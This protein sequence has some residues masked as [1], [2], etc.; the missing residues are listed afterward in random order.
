MRLEVGQPAPQFTVQDLAGRTI[1]LSQY[2]GHYLMISFHRYAVCPLCDLRLWH[3]GRLWEQYAR[4]GLYLMTFVEST[5]D[6][7]HWYLDR[8][9]CPFP[10]VPDPHGAVYR[11]YG[12]EASPLGVA[13]GLIGRQAEYREAGRRQLGGW[14][15]WHIATSGTFSRLPATFII[16]PDLRIQLAHYGRD[17]G[18]FLLFSEVDRFLEAR[19]HGAPSLAPPER[20]AT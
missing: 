6:M 13:R 15:L 12:L 8:L 9:N 5:P 7:T 2:A 14:N 20:R 18:D 10:L 17:T 4:Q 3:L 11:Q 1:S 19:P 16:G